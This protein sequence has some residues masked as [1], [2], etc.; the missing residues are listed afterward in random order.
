MVVVKADGATEFDGG[1]AGDVPRMFV[2]VTE[3]V[4]ASP[5]VRLETVHVNAPVVV[6][7]S[8]PFAGVVVSVAVT[9]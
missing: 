5:P 8:P 3:N 2:A 6:H 9:V 1:D 7:V 4:Y